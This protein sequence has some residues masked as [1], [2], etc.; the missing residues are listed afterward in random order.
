MHLGNEHRPN[1]HCERLEAELNEAALP[2]QRLSGRIALRNGELYEHYAAPTPR[3]VQGS[4]DER[5]SEAAMP[6]F[7][8]NVHTEERRLVLGLFTTLEREARSAYQSI[9]I[10]STENDL[11]G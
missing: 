5:T 6:E 3:V 9:A 11:P 2:V 8:R 10:E 7:G 1:G 4:H